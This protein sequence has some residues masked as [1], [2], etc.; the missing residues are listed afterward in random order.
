MK[1]NKEHY[2]FLSIIEIDF[3]STKFMADKHQDYEHTC[4]LDC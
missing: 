1:I 2:L 3:Q 4:I